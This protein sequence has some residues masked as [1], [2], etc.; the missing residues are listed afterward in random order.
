MAAHPAASWI[1]CPTCGKGPGYPCVQLKDPA[2]K[3]LHPHAA[4]IKASR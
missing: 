1:R 2:K 4:R 3:T